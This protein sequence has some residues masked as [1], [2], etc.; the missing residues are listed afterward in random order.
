MSFSSQLIGFIKRNFKLKFRNILQTLPEIYTPI[1]ILIALV[2]FNYVFEYE[3]LHSEE[4]S[5]EPFP[6]NPELPLYSYLYISPNNTYTRLVVSLIKQHMNFT[7]IRHFNT[8]DAAKERYKMDAENYDRL[9]AFGLDFT[10]TNFTSGVFNYSIFTEWNDELFSGDQVN[11]FSNSEMCRKSSGDILLM[12]YP[13]CA[14][15]RYVYNG[16]SSLKFYVDFFL[17]KVCFLLKIYQ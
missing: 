13:R 5:E 7:Y 17:K 12:G 15:N 9:Y 1:L 4:F 14:G 3:Y 2:I 11:L 8:I 6:F 16:L 10:Y